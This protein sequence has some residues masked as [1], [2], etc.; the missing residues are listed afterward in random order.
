M[1]KPSYAIQPA[2]AAYP[3]IPRESQ[4]T[5][6]IETSKELTLMHAEEFAFE[7]ACRVALFKQIMDHTAI[8]ANLT[9]KYMELA[10][11]AAEEYTTIR[12]AYVKKA[13]DAIVSDS[14][15]FGGEQSW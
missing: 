12:R 2:T 11:I 9:S 3:A 10:P 8:L 6:L 13:L 15:S 1:S 14:N 7:D 5:S 4:Q